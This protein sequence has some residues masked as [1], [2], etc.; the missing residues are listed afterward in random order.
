MDELH[1]GGNLET[2]LCVIFNEWIH[3]W[4]NG[5]MIKGALCA[6]ARE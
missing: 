1:Y 2:V 4:V 5:E 3:S 6:G